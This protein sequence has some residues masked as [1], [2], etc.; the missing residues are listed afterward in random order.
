MM[1]WL[2]FQGPL[3]T[4]NSTGDSCSMISQGPV[5]CVVS[6]LLVLALFGVYSQA[7]SPTLRLGCFL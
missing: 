3:T 2:A 6:F 7:K 4:R 1:T 5:Q